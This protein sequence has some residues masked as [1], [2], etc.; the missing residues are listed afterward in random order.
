M[1]LNNINYTARAFPGSGAALNDRGAAE[2]R[3][4]VSCSTNK[5]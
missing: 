5:F 2:R 4:N 3:K 1:I